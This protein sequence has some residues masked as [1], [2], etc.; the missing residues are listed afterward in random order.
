MACE[1]LDIDTTTNDGAV[2]YPN[3]G[4]YQFLNRERYT[5]NA[6]PVPVVMN[7]IFQRTPG[8][9]WESIST[10]QISQA[11]YNELDY[12]QK[13]DGTTYIVEG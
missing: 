3:E 10:V 8:G 13:M 5:Y 6:D 1:F 12:D 4:S 11:A 2:G 9:E 7:K